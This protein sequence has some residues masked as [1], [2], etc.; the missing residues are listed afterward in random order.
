MEDI[1]KHTGCH[2]RDCHDQYSGRDEVSHLQEIIKNKENE[3]KNSNEN[4]D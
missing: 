1:H 4:E 3:H 2:V